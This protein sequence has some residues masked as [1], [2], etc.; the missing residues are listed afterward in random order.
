ML[1]LSHQIPFMYSAKKKKKSLSKKEKK[2]NVRSNK[3]KSLPPAPFL[4]EAQ[5][6][7]FCKEFRKT[8]RLNRD[9]VDILISASW[10]GIPMTY[11]AEDHSHSVC[12]IE[13]AVVQADV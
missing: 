12:D 6:K 7:A 8:L 2:N 3:V 13:N 9:P 10:T 5:N 11:C 4:S 1:N